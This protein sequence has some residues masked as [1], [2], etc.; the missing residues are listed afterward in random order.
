ML[1]AM[2]A[3]AFMA[4]SALGARTSMST[5]FS[6]VSNVMKPSMM[7]SSQV[8]TRQLSPQVS[9]IATQQASTFTPPPIG[10][11]LGLEA[12]SCYQAMFGDLQ[13][14]VKTS[15][16]GS[17]KRSM[18][19]KKQYKALSAEV[20]AWLSGAG[21]DCRGQIIKMSK[22]AEQ[23]SSSGRK[24]SSFLDDN[25]TQFPD[26]Q[27][28]QQGM[29]GAPGLPSGML[30]P[31]G[32]GEEDKTPTGGSAGVLLE[33]GITG[34]M[35]IG[36]LSGEVAV[37]IY[38]KDMG[39]VIATAGLGLTGAGAGVDMK[40]GMLALSDTLVRT[41]CIVDA[42]FKPPGGIVLGSIS[43]EVVFGHLTPPRFVGVG[44]D[45]SFGAKVSMNVLPVGASLKC[46]KSRVVYKIKGSGRSLL[47]R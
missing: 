31:S 19:K 20:M 47:S 2:C 4:S 6:D 3:T 10:L 44:F 15:L 17:P 34:G 32:F 24:P 22:L 27:G 40:I 13:R 26:M 14:R 29:Q 30:I 8:K 41:R 42:S 36:S 28:A 5:V 12:E 9:Q 25:S 43:G 1:A 39:T 7:T 45:C 18:Q 35:G 23:F 37:V 21:Q 38:G 33:L 16:S 46:F 11:G